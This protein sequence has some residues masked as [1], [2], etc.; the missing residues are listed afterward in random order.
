MK[1]V[2]YQIYH[3]ETTFHYD[4]L[5]QLKKST[6]HINIVENKCA[7]NHVAFF[8]VTKLQFHM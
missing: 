8:L 6:R 5:F 1:I 2:I 7:I 3:F 4:G